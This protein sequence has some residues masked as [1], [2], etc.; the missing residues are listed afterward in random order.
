LLRL[1]GRPRPLRRRVR[2]RA[3]PVVPLTCQEVA[4][5]GEAETQVLA[6]EIDPSASSEAHVRSV[7]AS[8]SSVKLSERHSFECQSTSS[9]ARLRVLDHPTSSEGRRSSVR[10]AARF[11][12]SLT[13]KWPEQA[14]P[15]PK[16]T[17]LRAGWIASE[18]RV[19]DSIATKIASRLVLEGAGFGRHD[20]GDLLPESPV[21]HDREAC[22]LGPVL[23]DQAVFSGALEPIAPRMLASGG[24][25]RA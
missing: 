13:P 7:Q 22:G 9:G 15:A 1:I 17:G 5:S 18:L 19:T 6:G 23:R 4:P 3:Y 12:G 16:A 11:G 21:P 24:R 8:A 10:D 20:S 14:S 25:L 2:L